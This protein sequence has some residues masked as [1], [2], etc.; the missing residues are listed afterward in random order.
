MQNFDALTWPCQSPD[1]NPMEHMWALVKHKLDAHPTPTK[2][3]LQ[4]WE[5]VQ[6][7]LNFH[8]ITP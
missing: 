1:L 2:G 7:S 5:R 8:P 3:L 6:A 4:L